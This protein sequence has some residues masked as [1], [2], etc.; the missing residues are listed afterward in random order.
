M[1]KNI[2]VFLDGTWNN[3]VSTDAPPTNVY[4]L[5]QMVACKNNMKIYFPGVGAHTGLLGNILYGATGKGVFQAARWAWQQIAANY[6]DG[7]KIFIFGFSRGA[8]AARHLASMIVRYGL[9]GWNG[10][11]EQTFRQWLASVYTP[12]K[13]VQQKVHML[14]M[15]D[16]VPGN[17]LYLLKDR[18]FHL[19]ST[20]LEPGILNVRHAVSQHER[21][22]SFRPLIFHP[23][24]DCD[25]YSF[26]QHWFPGY[27]SDVGGGD[28]IAEGLASFSLWWMIREAYGLELNFEN[29]DCQTHQNGN[30]LGVIQNVDPQEAPICSDYWTTRIGLRWDRLKR[31]TGIVPSRTPRFDLLDKCP[32]PK[33]K[34]DM[35]DYFRT[36]IG[37]Q[38]LQ[39]KGL[40]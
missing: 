39:A 33:C 10:N 40:V 35:F 37:I 7:D 20:N 26:A 14:G 4:K 25:G 6:V 22:W 15:F 24:K 18:S 16:C 38:W 5:F 29:I 9:K 34:K 12:C 2:V 3:S 11:I 27:H 8:F 21:R 1:P 23:N 17:H 31:K 36:D 13:K 19:N 30:G 32:R 28:G